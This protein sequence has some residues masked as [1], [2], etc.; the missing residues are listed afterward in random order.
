MPATHLLSAH[1]CKL[2][3]RTSATTTTEPPHIPDPLIPFVC[4]QELQAARAAA[5]QLLSQLQ[6]ERRAQLSAEGAARL[7]AWWEQELSYLQGDGG[8]ARRPPPAA[9]ALADALSACQAA[10]ARAPA[11]ASRVQAPHAV[12]RGGRDAALVA[13][14]Q[15]LMSE[16]SVVMCTASMAGS[17]AVLSADSKF[18]VALIDEAAQ[19]VE[20]ETAVVLRASAG[21]RRLVLVGDHKQLP[22][23]VISQA[24][25][26][27]GYGRSSFE[28]LA[29]CGAG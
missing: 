2:A 20:A 6:M 14:R 9:R 26:A 13:L 23:T 18:D 8:R 1:S 25:K 29:D 17:S 15:L 21:A 5:E 12:A 3:G 10:L 4:T 19:L 24:A 11:A 22:A 28:R 7:A 27:A 16:A